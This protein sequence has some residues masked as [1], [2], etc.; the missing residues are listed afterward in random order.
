MMAVR[1]PGWLPFTPQ[2]VTGP[3]VVQQR[4]GA[5]L[6]VQGVQGEHHGRRVVPRGPQIVHERCDHGDLVG[7]TGDLTLRQHHRSGSLGGMG[8]GGEQ[9]R[10][11]P[12]TLVGTAHGLGVDGYRPA[13]GFRLGRVQPVGGPGRDDRLHRLPVDP[14]RHPPNGGLAR[15]VDLSGQ[16]VRDR[17]QGQ[18]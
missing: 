16:R 9:V 10:G 14:A 2:H 7:L 17:A 11:G 13:T 18:Q 6:G 1:R 3:G 12:V 4:G 15:W 8:A 5:V